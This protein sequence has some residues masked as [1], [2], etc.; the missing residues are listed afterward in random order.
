M[1]ETSVLYDPKKWPACGPF[2]VEKA[3]KSAEK[4]END[5]K[6]EIESQKAHIN[7]PESIAE[8]ENQEPIMDVEAGEAR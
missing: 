1:I 4:L 5:L 3:V 7:R 8:I 6:I 2:I